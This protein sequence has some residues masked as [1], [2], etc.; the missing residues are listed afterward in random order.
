MKKRYKI[1]LIIFSSLVAL[2]LI[3]LL[4]LY[5][6]RIVERQIDQTLE[7]F[8]EA[9]KPVNIRV[10]KISGSFLN[11]V[12]ITDIVLDYNEKGLEYRVLEIPRI[13]V[14]Y[15]PTDLWNKRWI[16][17]RVE[18]QNPK[19]TLKKDEQGNLLIPKLKQAKGIKKT[20]LFDFKVEQVLIKDGLFE[21]VSNP[22]SL[23]QRDGQGF[24]LKFDSL[25]FDLSVTKKKTT[26]DVV[27]QDAKIK[28]TEKDVNL[29]GAKG[30]IQISGD[31]LKLEDFLVLTDESEIK[32]EGE[33]KIK[34]K[35]DFDL[36]INSSNVSLAELSRLTGLDLSG[37]LKVEGTWKG[38]FKNFGGKAK[39]NGIF[40]DRKFENVET[41]YAFSNKLLEFEN[42]KGKIFEAPLAGNGWLNFANRP[43]AYQFSGEVQNL[44]LAQIVKGE[45]HSDFSGKVELEGR[46]FNDK[47]MLMTMIVNLDKGRIDTYSFNEALGKFTLDFNKIHFYEGFRAR[48]KHS[49]GIFSGD[50]EYDGNID[51]QA[52]VNFKDLTDF[53]N[54][55]FIKE[56]AGRGKANLK[57]TGKTEDFNADGDFISD[58]VWAYQFFSSDFKANLSVANYISHQKG[59]LDLDIKSG[60]AWEIPYDSC[61]TWISLDGFDIYF[62]SSLAWQKDYQLNFKGKVNTEKDIQPL[63]IEKLDLVYRG[64]KFE[65]REPILVDVRQEDIDFKRAVIYTPKGEIRIT[66]TISYEEELNLQ[67]Q[68]SNIL[69]ETWADIFLSPGKFKGIFS[70]TTNLTGTFQNPQMQLAGSI[71]SVKY[72]TVNLGKMDFD[73]EYE[74]Q[75]L[76]INK[77]SLSSP[78]AKYSWSGSAPIN[79]SFY[80]TKD[81]LL[82][83]P[84]KII[85][86]GEGNSFS[87]IHLF[88]PDIEYLTG[89]FNSN[90]QIEGTPVHP[91]LNGIVKL[92]KG[93]LKI[94]ELQDPLTDVKAVIRMVNE[95]I[96]FDEAVGYIEKGK[97]TARGNIKVKDIETF[98]YDLTIKG[99]DL[100]FAYEDVDLTGIAELSLSVTGESPPLVSGQIAIREASYLEPFGTASGSGYY[101]SQ[102]PAHPEALW[103]WDFSVIALNNLWVINSDLRA[104][105]GGEVLVTRQEGELR[106][107]GSLQVLRGKY[108]LPGTT[109][110]IEEGELIFDNIEKIDP[111]LHFLVTTDI[112][113]KGQNASS[114]LAKADD[115]KL[116]L[117]IEGTLS[118]PEVNPAPGSDYTKD[119]ILEVLTLNRRFSTV[120]TAGIGGAFQE[121]VISGLGGAGNQF[122]GQW[123]YRTIGVETFEVKPA[124][125]EKFDL[126][127]TE[128]TVGKYFLRNLYGRYTGRLSS[129][130]VYEVGLE[131]RLNKNLYLEGNK[132]KQNLYKVGL[133]LHLEF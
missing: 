71:D 65:N 80:K 77:L 129:P 102:V 6:T 96:Y 23:S 33:T 91:Q 27:V 78:D 61:K 13:Q 81:R 128:V 63:V 88:I 15:K 68:F 38:N 116:K 72:M 109:F 111:K 123:A 103:N 32:V 45:L 25:N 105:F 18:I 55:I 36:N 75:N 37:N 74:N 120:D 44:D 1:P 21:I 24:D 92:E 132:D 11:G 12:T 118:A 41:Q 17:H 30:K 108:F 126:L 31:K 10:G 124:W 110:D 82:D 62:D 22:D 93:I 52:Q 58:S 54:Q 125:G 69:A 133:N 67:L 7:S 16:L 50:L 48:Y 79:L 115:T 113:G 26:W 98:A 46:G 28:Q 130:E 39:I 35:L 99:K 122:L 84:Q 19:I 95:D 8:F 131:Y 87:I 106:F 2:I 20:F 43:E 29:K 114:V 59:H 51:I 83:Q 9:Q 57:I 97:I 3:F 4:L 56:M 14:S 90:I 42:L 64:V 86:E 101:A 49:E 107:L 47:N 104:E 94:A 66:G 119:D 34:D 70:A 40:M 100:P 127:G 85:F 117:L 53:T 76:R 73:V 60:S 112:Y 5:K 89:D 121:K